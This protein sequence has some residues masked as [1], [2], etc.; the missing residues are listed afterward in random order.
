MSTTLPYINDER[1]EVLELVPRDAAVVLDVGCY[2]GAF[3]RG[4]KRRQRCEVW[5]IEPN[6]EAAEAARKYELDNV[7]NA[8]IED[9]VDELPPQFFDL[10]TFNDVLEHLVSPEDALRAVARCIKPSGLVQASLPN[11]RYWQALQSILLEADFPQ[12]DQGIFDRTHLRFFTKKSML[13]LFKRSGYEI[14]AVTGIN[15]YPIRFLTIAN[16]LSRN[17]FEDCKYLQFV[18]HAKPV[19]S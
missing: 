9:S 8:S 12:E 7:I 18:V 4:L 13:D 3:G 6:E 15:P 14:Q 5:G 1:R 10:I 17:R 11:I 16:L 2:R 19:V